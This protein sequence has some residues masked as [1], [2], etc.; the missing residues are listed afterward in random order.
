MHEQ[1]KLW[2]I[3]T[4]PGRGRARKGKLRTV[5]N[6]WVSSG[7]PGVETGDSWRCP[8]SRGSRP[9]AGICSISA[10][11]RSHTEP[12]GHRNAP[13]SDAHLPFLSVTAILHC[14]SHSTGLTH[15][16]CTVQWLLVY[17]GS[18]PPSALGY[19]LSRHRKRRLL[20]PS[21]RQ[22]PTFLLS[23]WTV[24]I[25]GALHHVALRSGFPHSA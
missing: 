9:G 2:C 12:P 25:N 4:V 14:N 5:C 22:A 15:L 8:D 11:A 3:H 16:K 19:F 7:G 17:S 18:V 6:L 13:H 10:P 1:G 24:R 21:P 20:T 23:F